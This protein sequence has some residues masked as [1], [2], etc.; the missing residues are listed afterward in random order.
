MPRVL[1]RLMLVVLLAVLLASLLAAPAGPAWAGT[2]WQLTILHTNDLH[3]MMVTHEYQGEFSPFAD[4]ARRLGGL[5]RRA[6]AIE[7]LRRGIESPVVVMDTGDVF[8]RGPWH[9]RWFGEPEIEAMNLMGYDM[10]CV[11]NNE[12][13]AIW[14]D[15]ASKGMMLLLMRRSRFPWLAAN[16][17]W[18]GSPSAEMEGVGPVEGIHPFVVRMLGGVRVGFLG[19]TTPAAAEY[20]H[21]TGWVVGDPIEAAERWVPLARKECD[22]LFAVTH[23]GRAGDERLAAEVAGI[24]AIVGGHS[25]TFISRPVMVKNPLG[26]EVPIAQA[27]ELGVVVGRLDLTFEHGEGWRLTEARGELIPIDES[28]PEDPAVKALLEPYLAPERAEALP[29]VVPV[30]AG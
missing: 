17:T 19:L 2:T 29:A 25:H 8:T 12:L 23:L 3:G 22:V 16:L 13:K 14:D 11:G 6:T 15:P 10:L 7:Q 5:A 20:P 24:D 18:G 26:R 30:P 1:R 4:E 28:F 27:G 21:L 9:E